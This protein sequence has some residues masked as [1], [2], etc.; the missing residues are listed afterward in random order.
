MLKVCIKILTFCVC[1]VAKNTVAGRGHQWHIILKRDG[2]MHI[3]TN[4]HHWDWV[5]NKGLIK[6]YS[7]END[8]IMCQNCMT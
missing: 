2:Q 5:S 4:P 7:A 8:L 3:F 6:P 1:S